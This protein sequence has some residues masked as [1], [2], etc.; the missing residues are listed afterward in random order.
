MTA[1]P[2]YLQD[3]KYKGTNDK[4]VF[5]IHG[6]FSSPA[7]FEVFYPMLK[8]KGYS[9]Y[10]LLL[11][12]HGKDLKTVVKVSYKEWIT[13]INDL[14]KK[15]SQ[16]YKEIIVVG[17]S[18]GGLLALNTLD[19]YTSKRILLA[20]SYSIK[21]TL[22]IIKLIL[23]AHKIKCKDNYVTA[24]QKNFSVIFPKSIIKKS[25]G[26]KSY[27]QM[28]KLIFYIKPKIKLINKPIL[29]IQS[30]NDECISP[31]NP[32]SI[33]KRIKNGNKRV[34]WLHKS[35]HAVY[36]EDEKS[37]LIEEVLNFIEEL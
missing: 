15:L 27:W 35:Y 33:L 21:I 28:I 9:I 23:C 10:A 30:R 12:G 26:L 4:L 31:K 18:M 22:R 37:L 20:P 1:N 6:I 2:I 34:K 25:I 36:D 24:N 13:Q 5:F 16:E 7:I 29:I 8:E 11:K 32:Y 17:H 3:Y 14:L 19:S